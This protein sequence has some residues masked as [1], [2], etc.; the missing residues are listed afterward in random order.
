MILDFAE[1]KVRARVEEE[2]S[3]VSKH[4]GATLSNLTVLVTITGEDN[5]EKF[6]SLL[7][8]SKSEG[9]A[10]VNEDGVI[11]KRWKIR[12]NSW[13]YTEGN[14]LYHH[15]IELTEKEEMNITDL[16]LGDLNVQPYEY[17]E[18][19][20]DEYLHIQA[21]VRL[22][23]TQ[24]EQL[25]SMQIKHNHFSVIRHGISEIQTEMRFGLCYWSKHGGEYKAELVLVDIVADTQP[26]RLG[27]AF[28]WMHNLRE[29][30]ADN[31]AAIEI[32]L[33]MLQE[34]NLFTEE[35][36]GTIRK[37][38]EKRSDDIAHDFFRVDDVDHY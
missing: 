34:K 2:N 29:K 16:Q 15:T 4:T 1:T 23:E 31:Y 33:K 6:L 19:F 28:E 10:S 13:S 11:Q 3:I 26:N 12:N 37:E 38:C 27:S 20:D 21:K 18:D 30:V 14:P 24:Y 22:S 7:N 35:E 9:I 5:N 36:I 32:L 8:K 17:E 25:K